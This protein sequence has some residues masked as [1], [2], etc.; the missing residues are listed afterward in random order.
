VK[1]GALAVGFAWLASTATPAHAQY[2]LNWADEFNGAAN[3]APNPAYWMYQTGNNWG[4]GELDTG[5]NSLANG[6]IDGNGHLVLTEL[7]NNGTYTSAH[8]STQGLQYVGP[9]GQVESSVQ[10]GYTQ[11]IGE[12]FWAMGQNYITQGVPWPY[13]GEIDMLES[14]GG[15]T[16]SEATS[17]GTIHGYDVNNGDN[18]GYQGLTM[19]YT[20]S[21]QVPLH[22]AFHTYGMYWAPY[23]IKFY[24]D[25]NVYSNVDVTQLDCNGTWPFNQPIFLIDSAGVGGQVSGPPNSTTIFPMN[26]YTDYV[27]YLTYSAGAPAAPGAVS[28]TPYTNAVQLSWAA[29]S[30]AG[31]TYNVYENTTDAFTAGDLGTLVTWNVSG[32]SLYVGSLKPGTTYYFYVVADNSGGESTPSKVSVTTLGPGH[33]GPVYIN[34]G[35]Y[36]VDKYMKDLAYNSG[37]NP[38]YHWPLAANTTGI[39]NAAPAAVYNTE[40]WG[41]QTYAVTD[42]N[43]NTYYTVRL[44]MIEDAKNGAGQREFNAYLNGGQILNNFDIYA[45]AGGSNIPLVRDFSVLSDETGTIDLDLALGAADDPAICGL[46][47]FANTGTNNMPAAPSNLTATATS[48]SNINLSWTASTT[49]GVTYNIYRSNDASFASSLATR[50]AT[51]VTGTTYSDTVPYPGMTYYYRVTAVNPNGQSARSNVA[52]ASAFNSANGLVIAIDSGGGAVSPFVADTLW[53]GQTWTTST[54]TTI[55][56]TGVTNPAPQAVYQSERY[57]YVTYYING[58]TPGATYKVRLHN[59]E[60]YWTAA[61]QRQ[62]NV[63]INGVQVLT[64]FDIVATAGGQF[65]AVV[66]EF[67]IVAD[68]QGHITIAFTKGAADLPTI[69]GVEIYYVSA[70]T[71][72]A[73]TGLTATAGNG[74]VALTWNTVSGATSY[75]IYRS[76]T[77]GGEGG[78]PYKTGVTS[79]SFTDTGLTNGT[80]YYYTVA[81]VNSTANS[82]QSAEASATPTSG[83]SVPA[84]PSGVST[85][86]GNAQVTISWTASSGATSYNLYRSTTPGGEGTT[87]YKTNVTSPYTDTGLTN[88]TTYYYE[89]AAVNSVG[90]S[91]M[92]SEVS[93][94]PQSSSGSGGISI[95]CGGAAASPFVADVD[96]TG[97]G[98]QV[99]TNTIDTSLLTGTVPP[100]AVLQ[101]NRYGAFTYTIPGL[102]AGATYPVTLYFAEEYW[103][104]TG[105]RVFNVSINGTNVLTNFDIYATA[106][107]TYKAVQKSFT[108]TANS[109]GQIVITT[110]NVTDN[111]QINGIV[112]GSSSGGGGTAPAAPTGLSA[113]AGNAQVSLSWTGSTGA[114]SYNV[115]RGT[116]AGGESTTPIATGV[117]ATSYTDT[118][119]T[120]GTTY[121]YKVA[122]VNTYGTSGMSN[123]VSV[124]PAGSTGSGGMSINCGGA[125]ASPFVADVDFTGGGTQVVTNTIDTSLLT[126]TAPPQAVLQSNRYGAFTYTIPGLTAG[127]SYNVTLYFA[128]EY[129]TA[130][131]KRVFNVSINGTNVLTN[132]DIYTTA[133]ATNK[134]VQKSFTATANSSGQ[135]VITTTNVTDNAQ[136]N[137]IVVGSGSGGGSAPAAPS[138]LS[139]T[140]GNAQVSLSWTASSGATSYNVYRGTTAGGESTTA[141]ATGLTGT[142]YTNTG[143][144]NGTTYY[145]KVAAVNSVGTS[146]QS[147]EASATPQAST[148]SLSINCGGAATGS[149]VADTD[150]TGGGS[151]S[152]TNAVDT[153]LLSGTVP[154]QAVLQSDREGGF[155]YTIPNLTAGSSHTITLYF[156]EQ[157]WTATGKRVFSVTANGTTAIS[158]L[159]V[160]ATAGA[161][162]KAIQKSFT[163]TASSSGQIVL[164]FTAS[165]D[166]AKCGG[167]VVN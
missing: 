149:W 165:A 10:I 64:N 86:S 159:D 161:D 56:T 114:T 51:G 29:S 6:Y 43:P 63:V 76:M 39:A 66:N 156:V 96:F 62:F 13:C 84:A 130:A 108:A 3:T 106:G 110:T 16:F 48:T 160:Y 42:L 17:N 93:G 153:S 83:G 138:G 19:P 91:P 82:G 102:T 26:I 129:W 117:T 45:T 78:T 147:N 139:A 34:C 90:T 87:A 100:Q 120:N 23:N 75:N 163:A 27:H 128:E 18:Y 73:P 54:T 31:V 136:I 145:Y 157:Y 20:T 5:T 98:T 99:V 55:A 113:S 142:T 38:N 79:A 28:A 58:L 71:L 140:A 52:S 11:G 36:G 33:S 127:G 152:W 35:G 21:G 22:N 69:K 32:T 121:Y 137:G 107:A 7:N 134:A 111:A 49:S 141:I 104:A 143:L 133:G 77:S 53:G 155:T 88:G 126:G 166:Q 15:T 50:I 124:T 1:A 125:A 118:G 67:N 60:N 148:S 57:G 135:I 92:S 41:P 146:G 94:T 103:T 65:K 150:F 164:Q 72:S 12:A 131:G 24:V 59:C 119:L 116:T 158:N 61:G 2:S 4:N 81:A 46:E 105:K 122:A 37:G 112:I 154:P 144:T 132:F 97:G 74:Q 167:I 115:Y 30:T 95:N 44:H 85:S 9:Y 14:H 47:V 80:T 68:S 8:M 151:N 25:G 123:E 162:Y 70:A 109:S 101:S 40:R 89:V